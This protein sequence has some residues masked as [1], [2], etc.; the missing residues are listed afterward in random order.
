LS[1]LNDYRVTAGHDSS[2]FSGHWYHPSLWHMLKDSEGK[3]KPV[4]TEPW[5]RP[6]M[7]K[8]GDYKD[9]F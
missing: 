3:E 6:C 4:L 8:K 7:F 1:L 9:I 2:Y 5:E